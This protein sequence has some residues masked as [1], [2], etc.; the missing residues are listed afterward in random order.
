M[1]CHT[2]Q[3]LLCAH[4]CSVQQ[5]ACLPCRS[6]STPRGTFLRR[7]TKNSV[8]T[9]RLSTS[10]C[11]RLRPRMSCLFSS[12]PMEPTAFSGILERVIQSCN[13][14]RALVSWCGQESRLAD[15]GCAV[16]APALE[17]QGAIVAGGNLEVAF[18]QQRCLLLCQLMLAGVSSRG[19]WLRNRGSGLGNSRWSRCRKQ[20]GSPLARATLFHPHHGQWCSLRRASHHFQQR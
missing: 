12:F 19:C 8:G 13:D 1:P 6:P 3:S 5:T 4:Q 18:V 17:T 11:D 14:V 9:I 15:A 10:V 20:L 16:E 2:W 7:S